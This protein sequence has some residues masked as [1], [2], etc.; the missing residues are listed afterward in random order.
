MLLQGSCHCQRVKFEVETEWYLPMVWCHCTACRKTYGAAFG[1]NIKAMRADLK[2]REGEEHIREYVTHC[3]RAF[4]GT[5]G[6]ALYI[7]S[8][9]W[10]QWCWP[11]AGAIDTPL[12]KPPLIAHVFTSYKAPWFEILHEGEQHGE[13]TPHDIIHYHERARGG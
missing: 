9:R 5:C 11:N 2:I 8:E 4:C 6:S 3:S 12:P 7:T 13:D 1:C 10:P